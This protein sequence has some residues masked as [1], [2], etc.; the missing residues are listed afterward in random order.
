MNNLNPSVPNVAAG[1]NY[2]AYNPG[3]DAD[4][5][6][7]ESPPPLPGTENV[8]APASIHDMNAPSSPSHSQQ[9]YG[10][11]FRDSDADIVGMVGLQQGLQEERATPHRHDTILT[12]DSKY[13]EPES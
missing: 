2:Q 9:N 3:M 4:L 6:R 12:E 10:G 7:A 5:P 1:G 13:S 8:I 11:Q